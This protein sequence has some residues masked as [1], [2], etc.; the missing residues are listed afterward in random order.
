MKN[1]LQLHYKVQIFP[2]P[3]FCNFVREIYFLKPCQNKKGRKK[4]SA[5][6]NMVS[7]SQLP[8]VKKGTIFGAAETNFR[9]F[10]FCDCVSESLKKYFQRFL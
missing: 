10:L 5:A 2:F 9:P 7:F 1:K 6:Q 8:G 3:D 4:N